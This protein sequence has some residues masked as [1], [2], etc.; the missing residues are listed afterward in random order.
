M[1]NLQTKF[2]D[3]DAAVFT[4]GESE[5]SVYLLLWLSL[6]TTTTESIRRAVFVADILSDILSKSQLYVGQSQHGLHE[7]R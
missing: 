3:D 2:K 6:K 5:Q 7:L 1:I 4:A